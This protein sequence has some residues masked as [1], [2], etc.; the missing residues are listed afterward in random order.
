MEKRGPTLSKGREMV[1][2]YTCCENDFFSLRLAHL[3]ATV[4]FR[5]NPVSAKE[6]AAAAAAASVSIRKLRF[7]LALQGEIQGSV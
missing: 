7:I 4:A 3:L 5:S 2:T 1:S 6:T